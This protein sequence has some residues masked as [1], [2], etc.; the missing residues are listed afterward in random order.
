PLPLSSLNLPPVVEELPNRGKGLILVTGSTSMGKTT[1]M[2]SMIDHIN[3]TSGRHIITVEDPIEYVHENVRS[4]IRQRE[5]GRDTLSFADGL[6]AALRQDPDVILIGEMR[7]FETIETALRAA[8][9][10][11]LVISTLHII[12]VERLVDRLL[13]FCPPGR[14]SLVRTM[15]SEVLLA[16]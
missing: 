7:D 8:E 5:V 9:S 12:T 11:V 10:G 4:V 14:E 13:S 2:A 1:T 16:V 15:F 3:R 6:R